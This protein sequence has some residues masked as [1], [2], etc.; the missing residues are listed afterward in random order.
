[1]SSGPMTGSGSQASGTPSA[2]SERVG[3][4]GVGQMGAPILGC[5][6]D[7]GYAVN[8]CDRRAEVVAPFLT[9]V[10]VQGRVAALPSAAETAR[11]SDVVQLI[12]N[13]DEQVTE[14]VLGPDGILAGAAP[15]L[16]VLIHST[17]SHQTLRTVGAAADRASV[18]LL[19]APVSGAMGHMS[20]P[21]L[22]VMVG[23]DA[24][25]FE[26]VRPLLGSFGSLVLHLGP[27]GAGLDAK[28]SRNIVAYLWY[29]ACLEGVRLIEGAG[30]PRA[31]LIEIMRHT[32]LEGVIGGM[33]GW[34]QGV[35]R[36]PEMKSVGDHFGAVAQKDLRA[37]L[38]R[39]G[40]VGVRLPATEQG[41]Q[42][43]LGVFGVD[44]TGS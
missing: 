25:A 32:G 19:D 1:M 34:P 26:R 15:G 21:N 22:C 3:F 9:R 38:A 30:I 33:A 13:D 29:L 31:T 18:L 23:G 40:E 42:L 10:G 39:A 28:L 5:V 24:V 17:I 7:A 8:I 6:L 36:P 20:L 16:I 37:A 12:V 14:A 41:V 44:S 4:I 35:E 43:M 2:R 27:L 11:S